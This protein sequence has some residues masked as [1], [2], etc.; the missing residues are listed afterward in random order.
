MNKLTFTIRILN[1]LFG[2]VTL[3]LGITFWT[4]HLLQLAPLHMLTG[5]LV[6]LGLWTIALSSLRQ[7]GR[8][9]LSIFAIIWGAM[10]PLLG[11]F[12]YQILPGDG[13]WVVRVVHLVAGMVAMGLTDRLVKDASSPAGSKKEYA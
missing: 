5:G 10:V 8:Q 11:I 3:A 6:V 13:H 12:Q 7:P 1:R 2:T 9:G 4:G